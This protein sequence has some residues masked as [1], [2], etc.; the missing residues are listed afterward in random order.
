MPW[1]SY[2]WSPL[3]GKV[4][5]SGVIPAATVF[6][7]RFVRKVAY[8]DVVENRYTKQQPNIFETIGDVDILCAR[9]KVA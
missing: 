6:T 4:T 3:F 8:N 1:A 2:Q 9:F 7:K 5:S